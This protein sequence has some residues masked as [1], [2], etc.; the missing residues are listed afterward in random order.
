M[1]E[2]RF[3]DPDL[4]WGIFRRRFADELLHLMEG[5][6]GVLTTRG[7]CL[8]WNNSLPDRHRYDCAVYRLR[9]EGLI[10][11]RMD[12][13]GNPVLVLTDAGRSHLRPE[14]KPERFWS[15]RWHGTWF[16]LIYD[17]P[18]SNRAYREALRG[19]LKRLRM[20]KLQRSVWIS[21]RDIRPEYA[22]LQEAAAV[23]DYAFLF[24]AQT[25]LDMDPVI[26]VSKAWDFHRLYQAHQ[27]YCDCY[28]KKLSGVVAGRVRTS[29]LVEL[30]REELSAYVTVMQDD[31][32]LPQELLPLG[33]LG[34][35]VYA[36]HQEISG[37]IA[38]RI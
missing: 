19:F 14:M 5:M 21:H 15:K 36:L 12:R 38:K 27:W 18:E 28:G 35:K 32:L 33:Y 20:G 1:K 13:G 9:K 26:V 7:R 3:H 34:Q 30:A 10:A 37:E 4:S 17:V 24:E 29:S 2:V 16:V 11:Q 25:L 23:G 6:L 8:M 22:D 31:P